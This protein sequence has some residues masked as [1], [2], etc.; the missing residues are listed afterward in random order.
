MQGWIDRLAE[1]L[2]EDALSA[3]EADALLRAAR[4]VAHR[5][6]RRVTPLSA[7]LIGL[8]TGRAVAAGATRADATAEAL[9]ALERLLPPST[10]DQPLT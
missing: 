9:A 1:S 5:E 10:P 7:Y 6:E 3:T 2:G 8:A 4:D